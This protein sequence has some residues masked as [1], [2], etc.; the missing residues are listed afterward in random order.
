MV[1]LGAWPAWATA[2][3]DQLSREDARN[4]LRAAQGFWRDFALAGL[5]LAEL[6]EVIECRR[7]LG[8]RGRIV[9]PDKPSVSQ[10]RNVP[11][12]VIGADEAN[13]WLRTLPRVPHA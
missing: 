2:K 4:H 12:P 7:R 11:T 8:P 1:G 9:V 10:P 13:A 3:T 6:K 5:A